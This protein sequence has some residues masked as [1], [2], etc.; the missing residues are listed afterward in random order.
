MNANVQQVDGE[1][2]CELIKVMSYRFLWPSP[3]TH[4]GRAVQVPAAP[5]S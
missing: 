5:C 1:F 2:P 3:R 4:W